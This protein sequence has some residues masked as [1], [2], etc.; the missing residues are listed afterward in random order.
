MLILLECVLVYLQ[1]DVVLDLAHL[2]DEASKAPS[3]EQI[4][5]RLIIKV[6]DLVM[7]NAI[8][9]DLDYAVRGKLGCNTSLETALIASLIVQSM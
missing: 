1:G 7:M 3:K 2:V 6:T 8:N 9:V 5:S 4:L